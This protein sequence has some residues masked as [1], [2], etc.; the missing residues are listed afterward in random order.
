MAE[1]IIYDIDE[2][3][4]YHLTD[5]QF[6]TVCL[7]DETAEIMERITYDAYGKAN[8]RWRADAAPTG[9]AASRQTRH[10]RRYRQSRR[11]GRLLQT[12]FH[13]KHRVRGQRTEVRGQMSE[14]K[15]QRSATVY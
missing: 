1:G 7:L 9:W 11:N 12:M 13:V 15:G 4:Y 3:N 6:S 14:V 2:I 5:L 8:H 10:V